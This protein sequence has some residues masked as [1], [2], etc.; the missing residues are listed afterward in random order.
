MRRH[1]H[2][3]GDGEPALGRQVQ[4][5]HRRNKY[6]T[7]KRSKEIVV[8]GTEKARRRLLGEWAGPSLISQVR[9][10]YLYSKSSFIEIYMCNIKVSSSDTVAEWK[11]GARM[12][13]G[14]AAKGGLLLWSRQTVIEFCNNEKRETRSDPRRTHTALELG[15]KLALR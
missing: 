2:G 11:R 14:K 1:Y 6:K 15:T 12:D 4:R 3:K 9:G 13:A 10:F 7:C 8:N 5:P